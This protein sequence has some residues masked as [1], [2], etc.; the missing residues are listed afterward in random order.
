LIALARV[1][2]NKIRLV[3]LNSCCP[4]G[5]EFSSCPDERRALIQPCHTARGSIRASRGCL[6]TSRETAN[7]WVSQKRTSV[8]EAVN[9]R[10]IYGTAEAV[11]FVQRRFFIQFFGC[12][13]EAAVCTE[14]AVAAK[15][16]SSTYAVPFVRQSLPR[17]FMRR[18][19]WTHEGSESA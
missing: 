11:P 2:L 1:R 15:K 18:P 10:S 12:C 16:P 14:C 13:P 9:H 5:S 7:L 19:S 17:D 4:K 3:C 8:A 6:R